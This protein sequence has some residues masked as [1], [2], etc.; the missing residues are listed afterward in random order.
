MIDS[1]THLYLRE[2]FP[3]GGFEATRRALDAGVNHLVLPN[4]DLESATPLL[5]LHREFPH[6]TYV[7]AG[8]HPT[9]ID[10]DW[11]KELKEIM[12]LFSDVSLAA[13]GE[14]G[15][16]LHW[17]KTNISAQ[18]DAF[19]EQVQMA[20]EKNIPV[21][22]H[23]RDAFEETYRI[24]SEFEREQ[25]RFVFHSYPYGCREAEKLLEKFP[26][27]LFGFNGVI[28][29]KNAA[30]TREA[31]AFVGTERILSETD[32]PFLT[33]VPYRGQTNESSYI[34]FIVR[35]IAD[36]TGVSM[37]EAVETINSNFKEK[38]LRND[39]E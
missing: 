20:V 24:V 2:Y 34:P 29:F 38:F 6:N 28:T 32:S 15:V 37:E 9:E 5:E 39:E 33:P 30:S 16:D 8:L 31:A 13:I 21:I 12:N 1:H 25:P 14:V 10:S 4:I 17:D 26:E 22:V 18:L 23:S 35:G 11:K 36:A 27:A 3:D 19:G 7:A